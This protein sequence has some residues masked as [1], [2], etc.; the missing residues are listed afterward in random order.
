MVC[1][2]LAA[3]LISLQVSL[4]APAGMV[5][6]P[7]GVFL[8]GDETMPDS[9]PRHNVW[10]DGFWMDETEVTNAEF[11]RFVDATGYVTVAE[12]A[13]DPNDFPGAPK[14]ALVPGAVVFAAPDHS[15]SL[16]NYLQWWSYVHGANWRHP[17]GPQS[18][19]E[20]KDNFPVVHIAW[21]D[22]QAYAKWA[23]KRLPTEAEWERAARGGLD[24]M[25]FVWGD[26]WM[27]SGKFMANTFQG[28]F[29]DRNSGE[30][31]FTGAA[32]VKSFPANGFG[33]YD[34]AGNVWEWCSDWYRADTYAGRSAL[35]VNPQGPDSPLDPDEP[36]V[37]KRVAK[38]GSYLC[39]SQY[40]SRYRPG[41]RGKTEVDTGSNHAGFRC[42]MD[43]AATNS[44]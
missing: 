16:G 4:A 33:L 23:G 41:G 20:G 2:I 29:P 35:T 25:P 43:A 18:T 24:A 5:W 37:S 19:I 42:V 1:R 7:G 27:P 30:D 9:M 3:W 39:T 44:R 22:A 8:M 21:E 10:V 15:V 28:H 31:G 11:A 34:M 13:L 17:L 12:Q 38:G 14:E 40:C 6:I 26:D 32:P 36:G